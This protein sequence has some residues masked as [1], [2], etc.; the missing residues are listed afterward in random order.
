VSP[1]SRQAALALRAK[2]LGGELPGNGCLRPVP[3]VHRSPVRALLAAGLPRALVRQFRPAAAALPVVVGHITTCIGPASGDSAFMYAHRHVNSDVGAEDRVS[4]RTTAVNDAR[5]GSRSQ[6][7]GAR[8][9]AA[10]LAVQAAA[11]GHAAQPPLPVLEQPA[12]PPP[13]AA[14]TLCGRHCI[15]IAGKQAN[16]C[17]CSLVE[18]H[19]P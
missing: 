6:L 17:C 2:H 19:L 15:C 14:I 1:D 5:K 16:C 3:V 13:H 10:G 8:G 18:V 4:L 11:A 12:A 9:V 7:L